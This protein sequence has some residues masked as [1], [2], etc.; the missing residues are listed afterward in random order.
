MEGPPFG[1]PL[2]ALPFYFFS[3]I[4]TGF[5]FTAPVITSI[6][7][8]LRRQRSQLELIANA[9]L[10]SVAVITAAGGTTRLNVAASFQKRKKPLDAKSFPI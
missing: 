6:T 10:A 5:F 3:S 2:N 9:G 1:G 7:P 4:S 8:D